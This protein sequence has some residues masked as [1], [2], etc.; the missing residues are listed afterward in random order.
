V[1]IRSLVH[2]AK[3]RGVT[4]KID[5]DRIKV[6][7]RTEPDSET[8]ALLET[9]R[10]RRDELRRVLTSPACWNCGATTTETKDVSGKRLFVCWSCAKSA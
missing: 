2:T 5:G 9:L 4:F 7:A 1:D 3:A 8:K 6:E 10:G